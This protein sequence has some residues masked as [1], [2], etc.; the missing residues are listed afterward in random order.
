M[1][2]VTHNILKYAHHSDILSV[3]N[4]MLVEMCGIISLATN[5][6]DST[7]GFIDVGE[8]MS[9]KWSGGNALTFHCTII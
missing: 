2:N 5:F 7:I 8:K 3:V 1:H 6:M 4:L 9:M